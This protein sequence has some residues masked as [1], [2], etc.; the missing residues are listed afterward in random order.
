MHLTVQG[1]FQINRGLRTVI[2]GP[3]LLVAWTV[4][5]LASSRQMEIKRMGKVIKKACLFFNLLGLEKKYVTFPHVP[6]MI[7]GT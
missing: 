5:V 2:L 7:S 3:R 4:S 1:G 6:L